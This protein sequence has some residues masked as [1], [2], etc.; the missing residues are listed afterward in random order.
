MLT[1]D[2]IARGAE[3]GNLLDIV[4]EKCN[5]ELE[6][7]LN[8]LDAGLSHLLRTD[9]KKAREYVEEAHAYRYCLP[10]KYRSRFDCMEARLAHWSGDPRTALRKY[11][12][13]LKQFLSD[14]DYRAAARLH[15]VLVEVY[16]YVG[17]Y[18][19]GIEAGKKALRY[20]R[21][22]GQQ[23][24]AAKTMTNIGNVYH[25]M[26]RNSQALS[27][28]NKARAVFKKD[29]GVPLAVIEFNLA[30]I[31]LNMNQFSE[32]RELYDAAA[33]FY[34]RAN[35]EIAKAQVEY[36]LAYLSYL[37]GRY[38]EALE[39]LIR[40][41]MTFR[42][43]G[44]VRSAAVAV[45]DEIEVRVQLNQYDSA[46]VV[47][48][49]SLVQLHN[50]GLA[51][52]EGKAHYFV[53]LALMKQGELSGSS[54]HFGKAER[55]FGREGNDLWLGMVKQARSRLLLARSTFET[56]VELSRESVR[57][58]DASRD[59]RRA[60]D[61]Q[62][63]LLE[64]LY[65]AGLEDEASALSQFLKE[66]VLT[67]SQRCDL[68]SVIGD[69]LFEHRV[70]GKA[71]S[72]YESA[73][74]LMEILNSGLQ[75]DE[76][77]LFFAA[78]RFRSCTRAVECMINLGRVD[79][80]LLKHLS[81][82]AMLNERVLPRSKLVSALPADLLHGIEELR[83][84]LNKLNSVPRDPV[85]GECT[86][87]ASVNAE[88]KLLHL[89]SKALTCLKREGLLVSQRDV[90]ASQSRLKSTL[91]DE[92]LI[93]YF[94]GS[95]VV[96]AFVT[97]ADLTEFVR[98]DISV[99][100]LRE[101]TKQLLALAK[102]IAASDS[103]DDDR[104]R[105]EGIIVDLYRDVF[106][107][108]ESVIGTERVTIVA[109]DLFSQV[110]FAVLGNGSGRCLGDHYRIRIVTDPADIKRPYNPWTKFSARKNALFTA[111]LP[112][113][114]LVEEEGQSIHSR[115]PL[116]R[117]YG[118]EQATCVRLREEL[119]RVDGFLH[120]AAHVSV[121][122]SSPLFSPLALSDGPFYPF[123]LFGSGVKAE[124][125]TLS[126]CHTAASD[127][128]VSESLNLARAFHRAGS[129]FVLGT[130]WAVSDE[131]AL[132]FMTEFYRQLEDVQ[133]VPLAYSLTMNELRQSESNP[134][135]QGAF[136]LL[137]R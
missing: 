91:Q 109:P 101:K 130:L 82:L 21:G 40:T 24:N 89:R 137:G 69:F 44:D 90:F 4:R 51:Y 87:S 102:L 77:R 124:L 136:V 76:L 96:G 66:A 100:E 81:T 67:K 85:R 60:T 110:P 122:E 27:Y 88:K 16:M 63:S 128:R 10:R 12:K 38:T 116:S 48:Q 127:S 22:Q 1:L 134:L 56:A 118:G 132:A 53:G 49:E 120:I 104:V 93:S 121:R 94:V 115:F 105:A 73:I 75:E 52:E 113:L 117:L 95:A 133:D 57:L 45:L 131:S 36:S 125:V 8:Q 31:H 2:D 42:R 20:Y 26:D 29:G 129:R 112:H 86:A 32:A 111:A 126:G 61:S 55:L 47:G 23:V 15:K 18:Q 72:H 7:F 103:G 78:D 17:K 54:K 35:M 71:L 97:T 25:R 13:A 34:D 114:P 28:Y 11:N 84:L 70:W 58:F 65:Q 123:D 80:S 92:T 107:P 43:L 59:R 68:H 3:R 41:Q 135:I 30:N 9:L 108:V 6:T 46:V 98:F 62:I 39:D 83:T 119:E 106:E 5:G 79:E 50:L 74:E 64:I 37:E 19:E 14:R 33:G 99:E